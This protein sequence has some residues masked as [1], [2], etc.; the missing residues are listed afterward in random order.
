[1]RLAMIH[2]ADRPNVAV[3][4]VPLKLRLGHRPRSRSEN[5]DP[6]AACA[7]ML[8][9]GSASTLERVRGIEPP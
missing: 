2:M 4:L 8:P 7:K 1:R 6:E 5:V 3:R 9:D